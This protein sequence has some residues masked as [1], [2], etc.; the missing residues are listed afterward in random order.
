MENK[1]IF[2]SELWAALPSLYQKANIEFNLSYKQKCRNSYFYI[3]TYETITLVWFC[4]Y[5]D[6]KN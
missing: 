3:L 1:Q 2:H 4:L 5:F 6:F